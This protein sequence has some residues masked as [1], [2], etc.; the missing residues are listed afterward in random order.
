MGLDND[1][2]GNLYYATGVDEDSVVVVFG[3]VRTKVK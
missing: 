2:Q 1:D 3:C